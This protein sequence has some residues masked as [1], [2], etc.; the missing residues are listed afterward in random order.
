MYKLF[1]VKILLD[2][3]CNGIEWIMLCCASGVMIRW[4]DWA[5]L[6][7]PLRG[8]FAG[9]VI[10]AFCEDILLGYFTRGF[11]Q[12]ILWRMELTKQW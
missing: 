4:G 3:F 2:R 7:S 8:H 12:N 9:D 6:A 10:R 1:A 5:G 11:Y